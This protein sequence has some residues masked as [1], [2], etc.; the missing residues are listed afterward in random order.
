V[1][2]C[3]HV[4][5]PS[6]QILLRQQQLDKYKKEAEYWQQMSAN[7]TAGGDGGGGSGGG[8]GGGAGGGS[9]GGAGGGG[10]H[11]STTSAGSGTANDVSDAEKAEWDPIATAMLGGVH[12]IDSAIVAAVYPELSSATVFSGAE[13]SKWL[14]G[15]MS[16]L[17]TAADIADVGSGLLRAGAIGHADEL[18]MAGN[19]FMGEEHVWYFSFD[20]IGKRA[21]TGPKADGRGGENP[22]GGKSMIANLQEDDWGSQHLADPPPSETLEDL[23]VACKGIPLLEAIMNGD[24]RKELKKLLGKDKTSAQV[25]DHKGRTSVHYAVYFQ[26]QKIVALLLKHG[27]NL[28]VKD[29]RGNAPLLAAVHRA[30]IQSMTTLLKLGADISVADRTEQTALHWAV[31]HFTTEG[32]RVLLAHKDCSPFLV[33]KQDIKEHLSALH[34]AVASGADAHAALLLE[35]GADPTQFDAYGRTA[36][37]Y[38]CYFDRPECLVAILNFK[39][40]YI[41]ARDS[42]GRT[43]LHFTCG[44]YGYST[45]CVRLLLSS[46]EVDVNVT[47]LKLRTPLH[48]CAIHNRVNLA[49]ALMQRDASTEGKD[50]NCHTP[51]HYAMHVGDVEMVALFDGSAEMI[52]RAHQQRRASQDLQD[53]KEMASQNARSRR[54]ASITRSL[55]TLEEES[56]VDDNIKVAGA[57]GKWLRAADDHRGGARGSLMEEDEDEAADEGPPELNPRASPTNSASVRSRSQS[58]DSSRGSSSID[59]AIDASVSKQ[60]QSGSKE[61]KSSACVIA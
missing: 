2:I 32:I 55:N 27:G 9:G 18:L 43:A 47:D 48:F 60:K 11:G 40:H 46:K 45:A 14:W 6:C 25:K 5:I 4:P 49:K 12:R 56:T 24:S 35:E 54:E 21:K 41:N 28:D 23:Y 42:T 19:V 59:R 20:G 50:V 3:L 16:D 22:T 37:N 36:V 51:K 33:N 39:P 31:Q 57:A 38:A 13:I 52:D 53:R 26:Q 17:K 8:S 15:N 7:Q 58:S 44:K 10:R 61:Q 34:L 1:F 29:N 30:D